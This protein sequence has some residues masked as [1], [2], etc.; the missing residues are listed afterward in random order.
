M[1]TT[2]QESIDELFVNFHN[3]KIKIAIQ[4]NGKLTRISE[5]IVSD[6]LNVYIPPAQEPNIVR[7]VN[8][9]E[10]AL[11]YVATRLLPA[12]VTQGKVDFAV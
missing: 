11:V 9:G 4:K 3:A 7:T 1:V 8:N 6:F 10:V 2:E 12:C 5:Q